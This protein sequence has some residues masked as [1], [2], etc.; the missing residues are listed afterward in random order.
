M[1]NV[2]KTVAKNFDGSLPSDG[3]TPFKDQGSGNEAKQNLKKD[4]GDKEKGTGQYG[5]NLNESD[6]VASGS[7][8]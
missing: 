6:S 8:S 3:P 2:E 5:V 7:A 4:K 1:K